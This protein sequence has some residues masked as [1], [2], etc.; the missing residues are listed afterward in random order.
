MNNQFK[1]LEL[2]QDDDFNNV[3]I[4]LNIKELRPFIQK[5]DTNGSLLEL[6]TR[7][8]KNR[9]WIEENTTFNYFGVDPNIHS[10]NSSI[11]CSLS[12]LPD[13]QKF[14]IIFSNNYLCYLSPLERKLTIKRISESSKNN[15]VWIFVEDELGISWMDE[16]TLESEIYPDV[17]IPLWNIFGRC[18]LDSICVN[19]KVSLLI[20]KLNGNEKESE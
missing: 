17:Y 19:T 7:S 15:A 8:G 10:E 2:F 9:N 14:D 11:Y 12:E 16:I 6:G 4:P 20:T 5:L 18:S 1:A 13:E 3:V